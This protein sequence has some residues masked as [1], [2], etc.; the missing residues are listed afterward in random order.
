MSVPVNKVSLEYSMITYY[1]W[2]ISSYKGRTE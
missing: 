1:L 2:L